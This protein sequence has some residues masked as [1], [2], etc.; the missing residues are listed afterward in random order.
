MRLIGGVLCL[1]F[2][3]TI[4]FRRGPDP[5]EKLN[6]YDDLIVWA[7]RVDAVNEKEKKALL[8]LAAAEPARAR[9]ALAQGVA[10]REGLYRVFSSLAA[11]RPAAARDV[12]LISAAVTE[13]FGHLELVPSSDGFAWQWRDAERTL[14]LP[15]WK[16]ARSAA[17]LLVSPELERVRECAGDDCDWLFLDASRNRSRRWCDMAECGNR[18]KARRNYERRRGAAKRAGAARRG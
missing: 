1:D 5:D 11:G 13:S 12:A 18:A 2:T 4:G 14:E 9:E 16:V 17:D 10:L 8:K 15:I 6:D 7:R 3:N